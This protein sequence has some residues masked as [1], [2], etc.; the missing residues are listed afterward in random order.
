MSQSLVSLRSSI[1]IFFCG[2]QAGILSDQVELSGNLR[3]SLNA[4][5]CA[6]FPMCLQSFPQ[7]MD[8]DLEWNRPEKELEEDSEN[9]GNREKGH[10]EGGRHKKTK[11]K[12]RGKMKIIKEKKNIIIENNTS[13]MDISDVEERKN[14]MKEKKA[15]NEN[16]KYRGKGKK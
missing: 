3:P 5:I 8:T 9:N 15:R 6:V 1:I 10:T 4:Y 12:K 16:R 11:R 13:K 7:L 14:R 2:M